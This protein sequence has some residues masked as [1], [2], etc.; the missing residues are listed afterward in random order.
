VPG[1]DAKVPAVA[2]LLL[3]KLVVGDE[4]EFIIGDV[5]EE[6]L[7]DVLPGRSAWAARRWYWRQVVNALRDQ[8]AARRSERLI[9][10]VTE[11]AARSAAAHMLE[12][13]VMDL[14]FAARALRRSPGFTAVGV[15]TLALGIGANTAIFSFVN[16]VLLQPMPWPGWQQLVEVSKNH[17]EQGF[18]GMM[19]GGAEY[20]FIAE[21]SEPV[22]D[23]ISGF[24]PASLHHE[25]SETAELVDAAF[26]LDGLLPMLSTTTLLGRDFAAD[27]FRADASPVVLL[28]H[29]FWQRA[30]GADGEI[31][32]R[33]IRL[34]GRQYVVVGVLSPQF[35]FPLYDVDV[36]G[37]AIVDAPDEATGP[38]AATF[39]NVLARLRADTDAASAATHVDGLIK[40]FEAERPG[41]MVG[42]GAD[43]ET[44]RSELVGD[45]EPTFLVL[46]GAVFFVLLIACVNVANL[47]VARGMGRTHEVAIRASLGAGRRRIFRQ[48]LTE[49]LVLSLLGGLLGVALAFG[50]VE[51][52][53]WMSPPGVPRLELVR[54]DARVLTFALGISMLAGIGFGSIPARGVARGGPGEQLRA[55]GRAFTGVRGGVLR[56]VLTVAEVALALVLLVGS[57]LMIQSL[58]RLQRIDPGF[59]PEGALLM[60]VELPA[61][62]YADDAQRSTLTDRLLD[63]V[64]ALPGVDAAAA[65]SWMPLTGA[66]SRSNLSAEGVEGSGDV[67]T[68]WVYT[69]TVTPSY[70]RAMG[71][72]VLRGRDFSAVDGDG[73]ELVAVVNE[74]LARRYWPEGNPVGRRV[75]FGDA[76]TE[77]PWLTVVG[78]VGDIRPLGLRENTDA[79]IYLPQAQS[80]AGSSRLNVIVRGDA[81]QAVGPA[82]RDVVAEID[83]AVPILGIRPLG[84]L[85]ARQVSGPRFNLIVLGVFAVVAIALAA[86]GVYGV[87][88]QAV[89]QRTREIGLR[90]AVGAERRNVVFLILRQGVGL[91]AVG[92]VVGLALAAAV[93]RLMASLLFDVSPVDVP[94]FAA[95]A[96]MLAVVGVVAILLPAWRAARTD[97]LV[98]LRAG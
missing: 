53:V 94:T 26:V 52:L 40:E 66:F 89:Y 44:L 25:G 96:L 97:P 5:N 15:L 41:G 61:H 38:R 90:I 4:K 7:R 51:L 31:V 37:T 65:A 63:R 46:F 48:L 50:A 74:T 72:P 16:G 21:R 56:R 34:D 71:I 24:V 28:G 59:Q 2:H 9:P 77:S 8:R 64:R 36:V 70:F 79:G 98:A 78:V 18:G 45:I 57:G 11:P 22:F 14:K 62:R 20:E 30:F 69:W 83:A 1:V 29:G 35:V 92:I 19:V 54:V 87:V 55:A 42:W 80:A 58:A 32:G 73:G 43:V 39:V 47:V 82:L 3:R 85:V 10:V 68:P 23:S 76:A 86:I 17:R 95:V 67:Q 88:S 93:T 60:R 33:T 27:D 91:V 13:L 12:S 81:P 84:G 6:Y 49:S 75:K